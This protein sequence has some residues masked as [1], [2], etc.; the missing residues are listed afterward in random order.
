MAGT[1]VLEVGGWTVD[2][3]GGRVESGGGKKVADVTTVQEEE[4]VAVEEVEAVVRGIR[5]DEEAI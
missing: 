2:R 4:G 1:A 3:P 5:L